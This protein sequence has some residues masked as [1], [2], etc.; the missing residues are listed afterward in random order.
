MRWATGEIDIVS[1][2]PATQKPSW[3]VEVKWSDRPANESKQLRHVI[4][5]AKEHHLPGNPLD[6]SACMVTTKTIHEWKTVDGI[7]IEFV[8][9]AF[10]PTS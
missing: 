9:P 1:L 8:P 7:Q 10:A 3:C 5:F 2:D 4:A 6:A